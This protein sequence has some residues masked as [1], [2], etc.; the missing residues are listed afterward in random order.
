MAIQLVVYCYND[1]YSVN[2]N[3]VI[4]VANTKEM[5]EIVGIGEFSAGEEAEEEEKEGRKEEEKMIIL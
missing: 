5:V 2:D 3:D 4:I 1:K